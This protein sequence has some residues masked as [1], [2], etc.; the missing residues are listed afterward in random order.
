MGDALTSLPPLQLKKMWESLLLPHLNKALS[1]L[2]E[3]IK[4]QQV[5]ASILSGSVT[6]RDLKIKPEAL[7]PL[8]LPID[9]T[10]GHVGTLEIKVR[11]NCFA[12][13]FLRGIAAPHARWTNQH[14]YLETLS[15]LRSRF[16]AGTFSTPHTACF[17]RMCVLWYRHSLTCS[18]WLRS[19]CCFSPRT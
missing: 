19:R 17:N 12:A 10:Y 3:D 6:L 2:F 13:V 1:A 14:D 11:F 7:A 16:G 4:I 15:Y 18:V 9:V 8:S 5:E